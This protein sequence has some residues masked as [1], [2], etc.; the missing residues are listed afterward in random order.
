MVN[1]CWPSPILLDN[2]RALRTARGV[3]AVAPKVAVGKKAEAQGGSRS[4]KQPQQHSKASIYK[5]ISRCN[6]FMFE[7]SGEE[8]AYADSTQPLV[9]LCCLQ[10]ILVTILSCWVEFLVAE[11]TLIILECFGA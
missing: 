4:W 5:V 8:L 7:L 9:V 3:E 10:A 1:C 11:L 2:P 6:W